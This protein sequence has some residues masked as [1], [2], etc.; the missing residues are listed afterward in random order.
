[1]IEDLIQLI[2]RQ[3]Q[4]LNRQSSV[5]FVRELR[6][7]LDV[8]RREPRLSAILDDQRHEALGYQS[9]FEQHCTAMV[10]QL[11]ELRLQFSALAPTYDDASEPRPKKLELGN[12]WFSTL[13]AFDEIADS[14][15]PDIHDSSG[16]DDRSRPAQLIRVLR[17]KLHNACYNTPEG[18]PLPA[19]V[20]GPLRSALDALEQQ[21]SQIE[22]N[23]VHAWRVFTDEV[24][25]SPS[26]TLLYLEHFIRQISSTHFEGRPLLVDRLRTG[27]DLPSGYSMTKFLY[28]DSSVTRNVLDPERLYV[29][30]KQYANDSPKSYLLTGID[31]MHETIGRLRGSRHQVREA[32]YVVFRRG[33]P[34]VEMP[35]AVPCLGWTLYPR[36]I[37]IAP[38]A[39]SGSRAQ[40]RIQITEEELRPH[41]APGRTE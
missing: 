32:F 18:S 27:L 11:K 37:D 38:A 9:A 40:R 3:F 16:H 22:K 14:K 30:A 8:L 36:V 33:G 35:D 5:M 7:T 12:R 21:L 15:G 28:E 6:S 2:D 34:L 13:A 20:Q 39:T 17:K 19:E 24:M 25:T 26:V 1:M 4:F 10:G 23:H 31:Q 29:E 41:E